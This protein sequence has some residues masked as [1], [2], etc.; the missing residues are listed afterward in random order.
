MCILYPSERLCTSVHSL[1]V[2]MSQ[3]QLSPSLLRSKK[4]RGLE[5]EE[6]S[7]PCLDIAFPQSDKVMKDFF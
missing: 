1:G 2:R 5:D 4:E 7:T 6:G 3:S